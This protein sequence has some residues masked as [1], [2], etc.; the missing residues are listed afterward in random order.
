MNKL[1]MM[2]SGVAL[3]GLQACGGDQEAGPAQSAAPELAAVAEEP[4]QVKEA[5][6]EAEPT[7]TSDSESAADDVQEIDADE[8]EPSGTIELKQY[9]VAWV[10]SGT[11][12]GGTLTIDGKDYPFR[13]AGLGVG[14]YGASSID[15][16]G[17]VYNLPSLEAF[18]GTYGNARLGMTGGDS[19]SGKLWL[20]SADGVVIELHSEMRG[21]ALAGGVDGILIQWEDESDSQ[22]DEAMDSTRDV[23]GD[24]IEQG[25]DA[26]QDGVDNVKGWFK[27]GG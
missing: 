8:L 26:V 11:M 22:V 9:T 10:G 17:T 20:R 13:L 7:T 2:L 12:G 25:A 16:E 3:V 27:K 14:G 6:V 5:A 18:P 15:A 1:A 24:A 4:Q 21:L 19:G 23:A